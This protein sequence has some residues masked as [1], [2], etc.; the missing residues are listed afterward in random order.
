MEVVPSPNV[1]AQEVGLLDDVSVN[2]TTN[3]Y[4]PELGDT[5]KD[6]TGAGIAAVTAEVV[7]WLS[8]PVP[9]VAV[10]ETVYEPAVV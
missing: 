1:Q 9:L 8:E 10:S 3:G 5:E 6:A 2:V 7:V 4:T